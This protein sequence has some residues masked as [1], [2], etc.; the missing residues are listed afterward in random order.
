M[1]NTWPSSRQSG[2]PTRQQ[3]LD[4]W[5]AQLHDAHPEGTSQS[6]HRA[7]DLGLAFDTTPE[8]IRLLSI[9]DLRLGRELAAEQPSPL[10]AVTLRRNGSKDE[11]ALVADQ[12]WRQASLKASRDGATLSWTQ[13]GDERLDGLRVVAVARADARA[14]GWRWLF[15]VTGVPEAWSVWRVVFPQIGFRHFAP[16]A[17]V[18]AP[19][20]PGELRRDL[21]EG[22]PAYR[23]P[24]GQAWCTMQLMAAY[25][26][27]DHTGL[28]V[29]QHDPNGT[30]KTMS[31]TGDIPGQRV[32]LAYEFDA[33][34]RGQSG[35]GF[36]FAGEAVWQLLRG[37]WYDVALIYKAW[38]SQNAKWW[39][40]MTAEGRADTPAWMRELGAWLQTSFDVEPDQPATLDNHVAAIQR[41]Q[42]QVQLP[43]AVHLYNWH[44]IPFDNDYPHYFPAKAGLAEATRR[45][46]ESG[47]RIMPY[48][49]GRLWDTR[50]RGAE[51]FEFSSIALP[52]ATKDE[53]GQPFIESYGSKESDGSPVRFAVMCPSTTLWQDR[54][55]GIVLRLIDEIGADGV[56]I[57]QI[58]A[59]KPMPCMD[60]SHS[61]QP[62]GGHWWNEHYWHML[63]AIQAF[64]PAGRMITTECNA[65]AFIRWLDGYLTWHWQHD[66]M[67]P[68]FPAIYAGTVQMFG[69]AFG[70]VSPLAVRMKAGQQFVFGEQIGWFGSDILDVPEQAAFVKRLIQLRWQLRRYFNAGQMLRPPKLDGD[71]PTVRA[72][73]Q[74]YGECWVTTDAVLTGAWRLADERKAVLLFAN[75]SDETVELAID[76]DLK[77]YGFDSQHVEVRGVGEPATPERWTRRGWHV[78]GKLSLPAGAAR[79][80]ELA[81]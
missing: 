50:D 31:A 14:N 4:T 32:T 64:L 8:G 80:V 46:Q 2:R 9:Y 57:D 18:L 20:G 34:G 49:N 6:F 33:P 15:D 5:Q 36:A 61:H 78:R 28:Y 81:A 51:D 17:V 19:S 40:M 76:V 23:E 27:A 68:V 22:G 39:P 75:V 1:T 71:V 48:I 66:G 21:W 42:Q 44:Q 53:D 77:Q 47:V 59:A 12:G 73:W 69:R 72:D 62:G 67:A 11:I 60:D 43:V 13:P 56:Y 29:A 35:N 41:F 79:A 63:E 7:G 3:S 38:A 54:V 55:R 10:F 25:S 26:A 65:E 30:A 24:Y 52:A 70:K 45:L 74:W 58:A 37:D 16:D